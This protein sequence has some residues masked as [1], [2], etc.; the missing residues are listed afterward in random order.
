MCYDRDVNLT[1]LYI[2]FFFLKILTACSNHICGYKNS[3][4]LLRADSTLPP[5]DRIQFLLFSDGKNLFYHIE[6]MTR[7]S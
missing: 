1:D 3:A 2:Y 6:C 7:V 4:S 5:R